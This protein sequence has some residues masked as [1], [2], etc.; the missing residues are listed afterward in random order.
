MLCNV[1]TLG[2]VFVAGAKSMLCR[3]CYE[4]Y[5]MKSMLWRVCYVEY[6]RVTNPKKRI[7]RNFIISDFLF[8]VRNFLH[9][10]ILF[11]MDLDYH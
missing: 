5:V 11:E 2:F 6:G 9:I 8:S 3:V 7:P 4:D 1:H 10:E